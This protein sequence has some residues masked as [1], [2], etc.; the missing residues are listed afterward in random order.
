MLEFLGSFL[1]Y[2]VAFAIGS[3]IA[4]LVAKQFYPATSEREALAQLDG[5]ASGRVPLDGDRAWMAPAPRD[6]E[7]SPDAAAY[8]PNGDPR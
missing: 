1:A 7:I 2:V 6:A 8:D 4:L 5:T 3:V